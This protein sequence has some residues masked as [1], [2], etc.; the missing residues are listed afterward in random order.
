MNDINE[1]VNTCIGYVDDRRRQMR[2]FQGNFDG[3]GNKITLSI[4]RSAIS[5]VGDYVGLFGLVEDAKLSNIIVD[6]YV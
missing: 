4:S 3:Q 1:S 5:Y 2:S 6:G